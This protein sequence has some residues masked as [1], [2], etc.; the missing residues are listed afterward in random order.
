[1]IWVVGMGEK[2]TKTSLKERL[3]SPVVVGAILGGVWGL[4]S[5]F[6]INWSRYPKL[7][8][9]EKI[10]GIPLYISALV[11]VIFLGK[12]LD[13]HGD[14]AFLLAIPFFLG[15]ILIGALLGSLIFVL[16]RKLKK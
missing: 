8:L 15:T 6:L 12:A 11:F 2:D 7:S 5:L 9:I 14:V 4:I 3:K 10:I 1:L 13:I 16:F